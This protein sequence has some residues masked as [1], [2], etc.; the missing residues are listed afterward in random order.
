[1]K[2]PDIGEP[3]QE[4]EKRATKPDALANRPAL[5]VGYHAPPSDTPEYYALGLLDQV[6]LQGK[7]SRLYQ[8]LVQRT[9]LTGSVDGG[10]NELGNMFNIDGPVLW[11]ASLIHDADKSPDEILKTFDAEIE[12]VRARPVDQATYDLALVKVRSALYDAMET[13]FGFGKADLLASFAI[14]DDDPAKI[15]RLEAEFRK[16][17]PE[18]MMKTAQEYLRPSNRTVLIVEPK[19]ETKPAEKAG[20]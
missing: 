8:A 19:A 5:A 3:R 9:G 15:N 17:T 18:L 1:M 12:A 10:I 14:F 13:Q 7:D 6:L 4:K 20:S 2:K 11:T 16:V